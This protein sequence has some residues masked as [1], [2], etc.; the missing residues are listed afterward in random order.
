[1]TT[2]GDL[3][4]AGVNVFQFDQPAAY[5]MPALADKL[6]ERK[7]ALWSPLDIQKFLPTGDR[8]LIER[9]ARRLVDTFRDGLILKD[10]PDLPGIGVKDEWDMWAYTAFIEAAGIA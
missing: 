3:I 10:Y 2:P 8:K 9:E 6:R 4:D 7:A 5:D 1:M